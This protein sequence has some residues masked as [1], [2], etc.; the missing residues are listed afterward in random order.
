M[1]HCRDITTFAY[2]KE[3]VQAV[4]YRDHDTHV[5][6]ELFQQWNDAEY[7]TDFFR[8]R[9]SDLRSDFYKADNLDVAQAVALTI[10]EAA[11][12]AASLQRHTRKGTLS[13]YFEP[14]IAGRELSKL[15]LEK[16]KGPTKRLWLRLYAIRLEDDT[17]VVTGGGIKLTKTNSQD[18]E[19]QRQMEVQA[20]VR[21]C[22]L[23][24]HVSDAD[25]LQDLIIDLD[26]E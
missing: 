16:A 4:W 14:L 1:N 9:T 11:R 22:L 15:P 6:E 23:T 20:M 25:Q 5:F 13:E 17:Y 24:E 12:F 21:S 2:L 10:K 26:N 7:L 3:G 19:L 8:Q 18:P